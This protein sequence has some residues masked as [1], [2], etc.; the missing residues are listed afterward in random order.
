MV[1]VNGMEAPVAVQPDGDGAS[2]LRRQPENLQPARTLAAPI[3]I[4]T[5]KRPFGQGPIGIH[6]ALPQRGV[7][8]G[9]G[10]Q[11]AEV[12]LQPIDEVAAQ[13]FFIRRVLRRL[14]LALEH[15]LA[16]G[17]VQVHGGGLFRAQADAH[18]GQTA[19]VIHV[20]GSQA[21]AG[22]VAG[23][24]QGVGHLG[25]GAGQGARAAHIGECLGEGEQAV[26]ALG[27]GQALGGGGAEVL[28]IEGAI[29]VG[30]GAGGVDAGQAIAI[31]VP[32]VGAGGAGSG[33]GGEAVAG[34][35]AGCL[36]DG[37]G[38]VRRGD[39]RGGARVRAASGAGGGHRLRLA[40]VQALGDG[41]DAPGGVKLVAGDF[42]GHHAAIGVEAAL[43]RIPTGPAPCLGLAQGGVAQVGDEGG[44]LDRTEQARKAP[45]GRFLISIR[46]LASVEWACV[47]INTEV[48]Q[49]HGVRRPNRNLMLISLQ[50]LSP[51]TIPCTQRSPSMRSR[52][53]GAEHGVPISRRRY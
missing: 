30:V 15:A 19:V 14:R 28:G 26:A 37:G 33:E 8:L 2:I 11:P 53:G 45:R 41:A 48:P 24:V 31:G 3:A 46:R 25:A 36:G 42:A 16:Q 9:L 10:K 34:V 52:Q 21:V 38:E 40:G 5:Q 1:R 13:F 12:L 44:F 51:T 18:L 4:F 7:G 6:K 43:G 39:R 27:N 50:P 35:V 23:G 49:R 17:V 29:E 22:E 32:G 47:A 20:E